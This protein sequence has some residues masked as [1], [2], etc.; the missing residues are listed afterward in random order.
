MAGKKRREPTRI[1]LVPA[2]TAV[3]VRRVHIRT[4]A[5][6]KARTRRLVENKNRLG[7]SGRLRHFEDCRRGI[8]PPKGA[9]DLFCCLS[10][11]LP[12]QNNDSFLNAPTSDIQTAD[13]ANGLPAVLPLTF[14]PDAIPRRR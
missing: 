14:C 4:K 5:I 10:A 2:A 12:A 11:V 7:L 3:A 1:G 8:A 9:V 13:A 6:A